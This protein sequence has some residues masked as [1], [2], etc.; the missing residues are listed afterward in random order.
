[1]RQYELDILRHVGL[2]V[3]DRD[4]L[5]NIFSLAG[6]GRINPDTSVDVGVPTA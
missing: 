6:Q 5:G 3:V 2:N 1:M 4:Q